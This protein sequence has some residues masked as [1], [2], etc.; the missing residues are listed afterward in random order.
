MATTPD[1]PSSPRRRPS[2]ALTAA[3]L[4][5]V[6]LVGIV[7]LVLFVVRHDANHVALVHSL[8]AYRVAIV[9]TLLVAIPVATYFVVRMWMNDERS[10]YGD[11]WSAWEAGI[12]ALR[13]AGI[14]LR[15]TPLFLFV[16]FN[17]RH[18]ARAFFEGTGI[19]F[20]VDGAPDRPAP[21]YWFAAP[22][23][24]YLCCTEVGGLCAL[25]SLVDQAAAEFGFESRGLAGST[26]DSSTDTALPSRPAPVAAPVRFQTINLEHRDIDMDPKSVFGEEFASHDPESERSHA[27]DPVGQRRQVTLPV[28]D[29]SLQT[30]RLADLCRLLRARRNPLCPINGLVM[31][32]TVDELLGQP[33]EL[34]QLQRVIRH[35]AATVLETGESRAPTTTV[36]TNCDRWPGFRELMRR[37]GRERCNR[38]RFGHR[39]NVRSPA[40]YEALT[41]FSEQLSGVFEDWIYALFRES[42]VLT[43]PGNT[44][45][46]GLLCRVRSKM[47]ERLATVLA[48]GLGDDRDPGAADRNILYSGCYF[49][50]TGLRPDRRA[51][52]LGIVDKL[53]AEQEDVEW[54]RAA[55]SRDARLRTLTTIGYALTFLLLVSAVVLWVVGTRG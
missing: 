15:S 8:D 32:L 25:A 50:A 12:E 27:G 40:T 5:F 54:T 31:V 19:E 17:G 18:G 48:G 3:V 46:H 11:V 14:D 43:R 47:K 2:V 38:H 1:R 29:E 44:R 30:K 41:D 28:Q 6:F 24:I 33:E 4:L 22:D 21:L 10:S 52:T 37:V 13:S 23:G 26:G 55:E 20:L 16:G 49:A 7:V 39:F 53:Q 9:A 45:L 35:D 36:V 42:D 34:E 51:F